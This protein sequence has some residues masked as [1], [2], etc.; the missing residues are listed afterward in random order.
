MARYDKGPEATPQSTLS[1]AIEDASKR[2]ADKRKTGRDQILRDV[3]LQR[4]P[5]D[6]ARSGLEILAWA[7]SA[8]YHTRRL[9]ESLRIVS[10]NELAV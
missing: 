1:Q 4:T 6:T 5:P 8:F 2:L 7:D 10:G 9:A 3:A